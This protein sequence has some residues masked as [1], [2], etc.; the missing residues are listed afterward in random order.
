MRLRHATAQTSARKHERKRQPAN[1]LNKQLAPAVTRCS[2]GCEGLDDVLGGGL[3]VGHFYLI[4]G[5]PGTGKTTIALQFVAEGL[6][7]NE[8]VLYVTLSESRDELVMVAQIHG[9]SIDGVHILELRPSDEE[10]KPEAQYTVFHPAE[11]EL[12]DRAQTIMSQVD[13]YKPDRL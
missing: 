12:N 9:L 7:R 2:S 1:M 8:K 3:P 4:E 13:R 5:E 10:L 11:V 6:R